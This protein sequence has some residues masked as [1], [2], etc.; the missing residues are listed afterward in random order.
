MPIFPTGWREKPLEARAVPT[1][2]GEVSMALRWHDGTPVL[3]WEIA[4]WF[5][6]RGS[7]SAPVLRCPGLDPGWIG[8]GWEGEAFLD[9]ASIG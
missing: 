4:P 7:G 3:L 5:G 9:A 8:V 2:W 1:G 6:A